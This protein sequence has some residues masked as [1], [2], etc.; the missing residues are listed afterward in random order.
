MKLLLILGVLSLTACSSLITRTDLKSCQSQCAE[1]GSCMMHLSKQD[2]QV[3]CECAPTKEEKAQIDKEINEISK[4]IDKAQE[5]IK[6]VEVQTNEQSLIPAV[7]EKIQEITPEEVKSI[8]SQAK[9]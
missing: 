4:E 9:E 5:E 2:G 7:P 3:N 8:E 1:K 6:P